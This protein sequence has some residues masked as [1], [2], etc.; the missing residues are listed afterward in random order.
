MKVCPTCQNQFA[1]ETDYCP[2]DGAKLRRKHE[3]ALDS[4]IGRVLEDRWVVERKLGEGGMGAV[5]LAHQRSMSR[6]VAVKTL[7]KE[8]VDSDEFVDRFMREV[9][10]ATALS[11][12]HIVTVLD[13][14]Q[15]TDGT[16]FL[17]MELLEGE[18]LTQRLARAPMSPQ[19]ALRIAIQ[20]ASALEA[21]HGMSIV[22]RDLK[23]DNVFMLKMPGGGTFAKVLD[24]GI[25]KVLDSESK[26]T[27][28]GMIFGTPEYMSPEQCKGVGVDHRS[29]FYALGC[30]L[31][32]MLGGRTPFR[33]DTPMALL[34]AHVSSAAPRPSSF[35][36]AID[37]NVE[38]FVM[39]L[40]SKEADDR[41]PSATVVREILEKLLAG[42]ETPSDVSAHVE[43]RA[44][45]AVDS[46]P[47]P[48]N[49]MVLG[50]VVAGLVA[51]ASVVGAGVMLNHE[52]TVEAVAEVPVSVEAIEAAPPEEV[53]VA[54][55]EEVPATEP[56]E[57]PVA[58]EPVVE[59]AVEELTPVAV[60][61]VKAAKKPRVVKASK[62]PADVVKPAPEKPKE[63]VEVTKK[64]DP[65]VLPSTKDPK[66]P[67]KID[68]VL[69]RGTDKLGKVT[70][71]AEKGLESAV[72][73][74]FD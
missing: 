65:K 40:L 27:K 67:T 33:A 59:E 51:I 73:G 23:P 31:F 56:V 47:A 41:P 14:G 4:M 17:V 1:E 16:L 8:L 12:P 70:K 69:K 71:E 26:V 62:P 20:I 13:F 3:K 57:E 2:T 32:E 11:H 72:E 29:D 19:E 54:V 22:H 5:Y 52:P 15:D 37:P 10:V 18:E 68:K 21:A 42:L 50:I 49:R 39:R 24:F 9:Q 66:P 38:D 7:R 55:P 63:P 48:K 45:D 28:T 34:L 44:Y 25:A 64:P 61:P 58:E 46:A 35:G 43:T 36:V 74:W 30:M 60:A 6:S 53:A